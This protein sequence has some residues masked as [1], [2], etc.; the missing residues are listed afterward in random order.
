M[1]RGGG[2]EGP[3][4][5]VR[6]DGM[7]H[8]PRRGLLFDGSPLLLDQHRRHNLVIGAAAADNEGD[9]SSLEGSQ[10]GVISSGLNV[11][12]FMDSSL[13]IEKGDAGGGGAVGRVGVIR[14][15]Q[16]GKR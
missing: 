5:A 12:A 9:Q 10:A 13:G 15:F 2:E 1:R 14:R 4:V 7:E 3:E 8:Q 6:G 16:R 11:R